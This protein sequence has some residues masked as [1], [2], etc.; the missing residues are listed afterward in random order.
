MKNN[1][2]LSGWKTFCD[3]YC[4]YGDTFCVTRTQASLNRFHARYRLAANF[5]SISIH[6]YSRAASD[7]YAA[8]IRLIMAYSAAE[9]LGQTTTPKIHDWTIEQPDD[10]AKK[11]RKLLKKAASNANDL[12][13]KGLT[14]KLH[15]FMEGKND[16]IRV[17]MTALRIMISHGSFTPT[18]TDTMTKTGSKTLLALADCLLEE[19][20]NSFTRWLQTKHTDMHDTLLMNQSTIHS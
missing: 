15:E 2:H 9:L 3:S 20:D 17:A 5:E 4:Q 7:G 11:S 1:H 6:G 19:C 10:L 12:F 8:S 13:N 16:N 18:G 14:C